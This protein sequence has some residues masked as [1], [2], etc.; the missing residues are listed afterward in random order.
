M[1][2]GLHAADRPTPHDSADAAATPSTTNHAQV[3]MDA[4]TGPSFAGDAVF[5]NPTQSNTWWEDSG[6]DAT[7]LLL[8]YGTERTSFGGSGSNSRNAG[9][10]SRG[11][12]VTSTDATARPGSRLGSAPTMDASYSNTNSKLDVGNSEGPTGGAVVGEHCV[13]VVLD[14]GTN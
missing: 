13:H 1:R 6:I 7:A 12:G 9:G 5:S 4:T 2:L 8:K 11:Q 10:S 14:C 3:G